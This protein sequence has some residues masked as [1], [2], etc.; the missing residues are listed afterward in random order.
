MLAKFEKIISNL[1]KN[2]LKMIVCISLLIGDLFTFFYF[3]TEAQKKDVVNHYIQTALELKG[4]QIQ[5][6]E[7]HLVN[8]LRIVVFSTIGTMLALFFLFNFIS[9]FFFYRGK[10]WAQKYVKVLIVTGFV[11]TLWIL[12]EGIKD[13]N[14][15]QLLNL[16]TIP[17]YIF[18]FKALQE[19][20][21]I[22]EQQI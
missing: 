19:I 11:L 5:D 17:L 6:L 16:A 8:D 13:F 4:I 3:V 12:I 1:E 2:K 22:Q 9:Y 7:P 21:K 10:I 14:L 20:K 15:T 18:C